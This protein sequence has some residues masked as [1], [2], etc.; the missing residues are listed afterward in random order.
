MALASLDPG[1]QEEEL[2]RLQA[3]QTL[4]SISFL[5][6]TDPPVM[7]SLALKPEA[8]SELEKSCDDDLEEDIVNDVVME[9]VKKHVNSEE[10][11]VEPA[12]K[13]EAKEEREQEEVE[14]E[15][16]ELREVLTS[17]F[18]TDPSLRHKG[19]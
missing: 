13:G 6:S 19:A 2:A 11:S 17:Q 4:P 1:Q 16:A 8:A 12:V 3:G 14:A 15:E 9:D 7:G 10:G 5:A 18:C